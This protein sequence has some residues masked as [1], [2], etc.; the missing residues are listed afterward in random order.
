MLKTVDGVLY[1]VAFL[2]N[3][4]DEANRL[5]SSLSNK[6]EDWRHAHGD[7]SDAYYGD[8]VDDKSAVILSYKNDSAYGGGFKFAQLIY[9][10][11]SLFQKAQEIER[12]DL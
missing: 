6:Y 9:L 3:D 4:I 10:D 5:K 7:T 12:A 1:T 11:R 2:I 8:F